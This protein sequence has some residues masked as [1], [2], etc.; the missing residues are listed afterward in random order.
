MEPNTLQEAV[1]Y[2]ASPDNCREYVVARRWPN[3]VTCPRCG[4]TKVL[5]QPKYNR[6]QWG[7]NHPLR[8][9]TSKTGTTLE[10]SPLSPDK[11]HLAM[12]RVLNPKIAASA[13]A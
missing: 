6:W 8:Q 5:F 7:S 4:G 10:D 12:W 1:I 13:H 11:L 2:F 3:G 9:F